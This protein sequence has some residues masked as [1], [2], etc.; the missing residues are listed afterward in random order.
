MGRKH[1][2]EVTTLWTGN[3][4]QGT[5]DYRAYGRDHEPGSSPGRPPIAASSDPVFRRAP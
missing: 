2:Y 1:A 3:R 5:A 4:G